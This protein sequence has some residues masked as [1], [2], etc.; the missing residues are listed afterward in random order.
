MH[1][2]IA[3]I[4]DTLLGYEDHGIFT[5]ILYLDYGDSTSQGAG[6][7]SLDSFDEKRKRR[8]G[9]EFGMEF[10]IRIMRVCGVNDWSK[11][12]GT[13]VL[14]LFDKEG[15]NQTVRGI[16][17]LPTEGKEVFIFNDLVNEYFPYA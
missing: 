4:A 2:K 7:Y 13:T 16:Q 12:K 10:I 6:M 1:T 15:W 5:L 14:A 3:K 8:V 9:T 17:S 11:V